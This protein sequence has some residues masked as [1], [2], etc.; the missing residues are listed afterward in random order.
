MPTLTEIEDRILTLIRAADLGDGVE[1]GSLPLGRQSER[2][3]QF[4]RAAVWVAYAGSTAAPSKN[5]TAHT[6]LRTTRWSVLVLALDY[7]GSGE[8]AGQALPL[9]EAVVDSLTGAEA[10]SE[11]LT[12]V[13]DGLIDA[14]KPGVVGYEAVFAVDVYFRR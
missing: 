10:A 4:R 5:M 9:L 3:Y 2:L 7:R 6:Q 13:R 1:I 8:A 12:L 14:G 11:V